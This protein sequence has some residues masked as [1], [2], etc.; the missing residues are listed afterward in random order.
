[1]LLLRFPYVSL[2]I[3]VVFASFSVGEEP[4]NISRE[5]PSPREQ[6]DDRSKP[7]I[8]SLF[9][10]ILSPRAVEVDVMNV[11]GCECLPFELCAAMLA[12]PMGEI[13]HPS[14][15]SGSEEQ[16][17]L[18]VTL[19]RPRVADRAAPWQLAR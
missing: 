2:L 4:G 10:K 18:H 5:N 6:S 11:G 19:R 1:M 17:R 8:A 13:G 16:A 3:C 15:L 12:E 7:E 9:K 14:V